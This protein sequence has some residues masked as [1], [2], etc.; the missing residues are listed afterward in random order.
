MLNKSSHIGLPEKE[1][2]TEANMVSRSDTDQ[3]WL[4]T[5]SRICYWFTLVLCTEIQWKTLFA[6][7][8]IQSYIDKYN[9]AIHVQWTGYREKYKIT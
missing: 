5:G 1:K 6:S 3:A 7:Y 8:P 4:L 9:Q 2:V